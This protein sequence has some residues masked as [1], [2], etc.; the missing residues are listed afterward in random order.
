[1]SIYILKLSNNEELIAEFDHDL[2]DDLDGFVCTSP[3][4]VIGMREDNPYGAGGMRLRNALV[5]SD[6][7]TLVI[8]SRFVMSWYEPSVAIKEY[9]KTAVLYNVAYSKNAVDL[10]IMKASNELSES[11]KLIQGHSN[12]IGSEDSDPDV[13]DAMD[14]FA[15]IMRATPRNKLQ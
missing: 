13:T 3:M 8:R 10:Q 5:L 15:R 4:S 9:Y 14:E 12:T 11:I 6:Q 1:M 2:S 7:D